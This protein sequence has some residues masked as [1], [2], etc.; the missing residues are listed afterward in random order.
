MTTLTITPRGGANIRKIDVPSGDAVLVAPNGSGT[1][2][3]AASGANVLIRF[4]SPEADARDFIVVHD[5]DHRTVKL[6][7]PAYA[8]A[9]RDRPLDDN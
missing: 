9:F 6:V 7:A 3:M 1:V 5:G 8:R 4:G 2:D